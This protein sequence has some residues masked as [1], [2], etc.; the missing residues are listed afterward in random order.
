[1][2]PAIKLSRERDNLSSENLKYY[3]VKVISWFTNLHEMI[4][5]R[6]PL[7]GLQLNLCSSPMWSPMSGSLPWRSGWLSCWLLPVWSQTILSSSPQD[8]PQ[9]R[10]IVKQIVKLGDWS[11]SSGVYNTFYQRFVSSWAIPMCHHVNVWTSFCTRVQYCAI[12]I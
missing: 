10:S 2:A 12:N 11:T 3:L 6:F 8:L 7:W 9:Q 1:M 4:P 5:F